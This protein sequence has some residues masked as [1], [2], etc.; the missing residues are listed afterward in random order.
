VEDLVEKGDFES[1]VKIMLKMNGYAK[2]VFSVS[3]A[4]KAQYETVGND[5][6]APQDNKEDLFIK[7]RGLKQLVSRYT[8]YY[9]ASAFNLGYVHAKLGET[10]KSRKYLV[11]FLQMTPYSNG[12]DSQWIKAKTLLL[13]LYSLEGDF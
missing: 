4:I 1:A 3:K 5:P 6:E 8:N 7:L 9:E 13:Q 11:E 10:E 2:K 12:H